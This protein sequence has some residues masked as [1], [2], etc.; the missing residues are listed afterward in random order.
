MG[1]RAPGGWLPSF[2]WGVF[3]FSF[4]DVVERKPVCVVDGYLH[5]VD[6]C[7]PDVAMSC[8]PD[9]A[10]SFVPNTLGRDERFARLRRRDTWTSNA[11]KPPSMDVKGP[12]RPASYC[13]SSPASKRRRRSARPMPTRWH[14]VNEEKEG[15][16]R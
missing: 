15:E 2:C 8:I 6:A 10:V 3:A 4:P 14:T 13:M 1:A 16:G 11:G 5:M 9:M 12:N 7:F